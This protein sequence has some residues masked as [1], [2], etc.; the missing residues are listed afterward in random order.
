MEGDVVQNLA[1][2]LLETSIEINDSVQ[3]V[4]IM[5][6]FVRNGWMRE[7]NEQV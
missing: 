1:D 6:H 7:R 3:N 5:T 4:N 2:L